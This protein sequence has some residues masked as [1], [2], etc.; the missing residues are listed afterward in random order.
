[1][2]N[3]LPDGPARSAA[4]TIATVTWVLTLA[5]NLNPFMRFDGY[6]LLSDA[7][8][9]E[10][11]QDRSF[12]H[13]RW[14]L[15]EKLFGL[16]EAV[17]EIF[18]PRMARFLIAYAIA[19]WI[20]R[21]FLF[22]GIAVLVYAFFFKALGI[23]LFAAELIWFIGLPI[24]RE[25]LEWWKRRSNVRLNVNSGTTL[26]FSAM[27]VVF[28]IV[29]WRTTVPVAAVLQAEDHARI[30]APLAAQVQAVLVSQG[31]EVRKDQVLIKLRSPGLEYKIENARR[32]LKLVSIQ[33]RR[34]AA[35][36]QEAENIR[37]LQRRLA[38][39]I[40]ALRG[41]Q[42]QQTQLMVRAPISGRVVYIDNSLATGLWVNDT[43]PMIQLVANGTARLEG[44]VDER[45]LGSISDDAA[46][47]FYPDDPTQPSF[48]VR[49]NEVADVN[50]PVLDVPYLA[51]VY[52]GEI[53]V[54]VDD[55]GALIPTHGIY[56][57]SLTPELALDAPVSVQRG[58]VR[59][60]GVP[61]SLFMRAWKRAW[62]VVLRESGF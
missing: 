57:V 7:I 60:E 53:P 3:F 22:L 36:R 13:A 30:F 6:Y 28:L 42:Q 61:E 62:S 10:N 17:P 43:R 41:L 4:F 14:W 39:E 19:T 16:G 51:S 56:R 50:S 49:V 20:Y 1:M 58:V 15:R 32:S 47:V 45:E 9:V 26:L 11:L 12:A 24:M 34:E 8:E 40:T 25:I 52:G 59:I 38:A 48:A 54:E 18:S 44:Y 27:L 33:V 21:F 2:W 46:A 55:S 23:I 5:V 29:P 35:A 37:V 31:D